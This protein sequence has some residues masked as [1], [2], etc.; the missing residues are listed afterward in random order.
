MLELVEVVVIVNCP[1]ELIW[2]KT[3]SVWLPQPNRPIRLDSASVELIRCDRVN[4]HYRQPLHLQINHIL[5]LVVKSQHYIQLLHLKRGDLICIESFRLLDPHRDVILVNSAIP[6][7]V[8]RYR[9]D[10]RG[11]H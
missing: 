6:I 9:L 7:L 4:L 10:I 11:P 2:L 3:Q 1:G 5:K 8:Q